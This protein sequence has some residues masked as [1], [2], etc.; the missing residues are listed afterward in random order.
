MKIYVVTHEPIDIDL[1][2]NYE[3]FQVGAAVNGAFCEHNDAVGE[4]N[5]SVKNP[6]YCELTAAYWIWKNDHENDIVG[7]MHYRRFLTKSILS[8]SIKHLIDEKTVIRD[9]RKYDFLVPNQIDVM[10]NVKAQM[11]AGAVR[12]ESFDILE[13]VICNLYPDY[14]SAFAKVF[15]GDKTYICNIFI[16]KKKD[17]DEYYSWL[18][19]IFNEMEKYVDMTGYT[20][21]EQRLYGYL[22]ERLF[23]VYIA[24]NIKRVKKMRMLTL[25]GLSFVKRIIN[26]FKRIFHR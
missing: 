24:K 6:N 9:L 19:S 4:D 8:N 2:A 1:P 20:K 25:P 16:A 7:L 10:P 17:W 15:Y 12:Q 23:S 14:K 26:K 13:Q 22:S 11:L 21:Q 5:I 18:F 3:L